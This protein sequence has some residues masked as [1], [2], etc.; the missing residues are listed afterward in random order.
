M[1]DARGPATT[2]GRVPPT[3]RSI[4]SAR[5]H[6]E[7]VTG[8]GAIVVARTTGARCC[9]SESSRPF[10][11]RRVRPI[12][13]RSCPRGIIDG[14]SS[15]RRCRSRPGRSWSGYEFAE[16]LDVGGDLL[17]G[18]LHGLVLVRVEAGEDPSADEAGRGGT[19]RRPA[20]RSMSARSSGE[21]RVATVTDLFGR[22]A[23]AP[24]GIAWSAVT[25]ASEAICSTTCLASLTALAPSTIRLV[26]FHL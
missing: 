6:V 24:G 13:C 9:R 20:R 21:R 1:P 22:E 12:R 4:H 8:S 23:T 7:P 3:P 10:L 17:D 16:S 18:A 11:I 15:R 26:P 2:L 19:S 5:I 14:C 25:S